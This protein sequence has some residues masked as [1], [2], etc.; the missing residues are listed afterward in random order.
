[1]PNLRSALNLD[2][3]IGPT[4]DQLPSL[5]PILMLQSKEQRCLLLIITGI[6]FCSGLY[7]CWYKLE[8]PTTNRAACRTVP[9]NRSVMVRSVRETSWMENLKRSLSARA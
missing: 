5:I 6:D 4:C 3:R 8:S 7:Q 2:P 1:M 9:P